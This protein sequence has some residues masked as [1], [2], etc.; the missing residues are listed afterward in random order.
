MENSNFDPLFENVPGFYK[1]IRL[2]QFRKTEGVSFDILPLEVLP[3][4]DGVDRVIHKYNA[5]S[6]GPVDGVERPWYMHQAQDDYLMVLSGTRYVDIYNLDYDK[7]ESFVVTANSVHKNDELIF[8]GPVMLVWPKGVFHRIRS[9]EGGSASLNFAIRYD[10]FDVKTNFS[11][12]N[13]NTKNGE[14][15]VIRDGYLD[16]NGI[17]S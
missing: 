6:P 10:D 2:Q 3:R 4:I 7:M 14:Y 8:D 11:I 17:E 15:K 12:Y 5:V 13:L 9:A 16:Q 1:I